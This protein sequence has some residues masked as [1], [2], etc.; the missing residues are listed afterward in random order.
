MRAAQVIRV[1]QASCHP[2]NLILS[3]YSLVKAEGFKTNNVFV[4]YV[5]VTK[6]QRCSWLQNKADFLVPT[7]LF[8][9]CDGLIRVGYLHY[10][11][12]VW[13]Q[14]TGGAKSEL[15]TENK[16]LY[17]SRWADK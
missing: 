5:H 11:N 1:W 16:P 13:G 8:C 4:V 17:D 3:T 2:C 12:Y 10:E 14:N 6:A 9:V 15:G 7:L